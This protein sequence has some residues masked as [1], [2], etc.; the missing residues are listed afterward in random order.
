VFFHDSEAPIRIDNF[1]FFV[2]KTV[3]Y[4]ILESFGQGQT[5]EKIVWILKKDHRRGQSASD[6]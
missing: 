3:E 6:R 4:K 5:D 2:F 1:T